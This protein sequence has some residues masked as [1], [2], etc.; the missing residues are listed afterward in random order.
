[1]NKKKLVLGLDLT[2]QKLYNLRQTTKNLN[3][4]KKAFKDY[5]KNSKETDFE[6][7]IEQQPNNQTLFKQHLIMK[8]ETY[9]ELVREINNEMVHGDLYEDTRLK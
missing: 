7:Y 2:Q 9:D 4:I 5:M 1:M 3:P 8:P 6:K